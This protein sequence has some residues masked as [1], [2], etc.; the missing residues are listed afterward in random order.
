MAAT[1]IDTTDF[2]LGMQGI[3][4]RLRSGGTDTGRLRT[5]VLLPEPIVRAQRHRLPPLAVELVQDGLDDL[6]T[7]E[8]VSLT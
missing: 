8:D 6:Q 3:I 1:Y 5:L 7:R 4:V 2:R